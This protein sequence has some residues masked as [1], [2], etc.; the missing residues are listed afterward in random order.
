[1]TS[2]SDS[3]TVQHLRHRPNTTQAQAREARVFGPDYERMID[4]PSIQIVYNFNMNGV[5]RGDQLRAHRGCGQRRN[6]GGGWHALAWTFLLDTVLV[7]TYILQQ[8]GQCSWETYRSQAD[9]RETLTEALF[10]K[11]VS[12]STLRKRFRS[13]NEFLPISQHNHVKAEIYG[14]CKGC[15]GVRLG[16]LIT[17][18]SNRRRPVV[19]RA[20]V[21][22]TYYSCDT[23]KVPLCTLGNCWDYFHQPIC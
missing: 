16:D 10:R 13:G 4:T 22:Q 23:C 1:M 20:K 6:R 7:N 18:S 8:K 14:R 9:W 5:D 17:Q 21:R 2:F 12:A 19:P 3:E 11:Y 15:Q